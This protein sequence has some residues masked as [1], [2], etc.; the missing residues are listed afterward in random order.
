MKTYTTI[1]GDMWDSIAF[2]QMGSVDY[3]DQ[4]INA[5]LKY[6]AYY[7]FPAG[8]VLTIPDIVVPV[9]ELMPPWKQVVG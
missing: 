7:I 8:I 9:S 4:L 1:Q 2:Q 3:T 6:H 5:N